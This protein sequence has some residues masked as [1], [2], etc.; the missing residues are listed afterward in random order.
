VGERLREREEKNEKE[1][2]IKRERK[3][4]GE[5]E[6]E[7]ERERSQ[8]E[9]WLLHN[10]VGSLRETFMTIGNKALRTKDWALNLRLL[11]NLQQKNETIRSNF[12]IVNTFVIRVT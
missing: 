11:W 12:P 6:R 7:R 3:R 2:E 8:K 9:T 5:K 10:T 4:E 1:K